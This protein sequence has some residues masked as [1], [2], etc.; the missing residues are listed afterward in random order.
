MDNNEYEG[1]NWLSVALHN[2]RLKACVCIREASK[3]AAVVKSIRVDV[4]GHRRKMTFLTFCHSLCAL[5]NLGF[6][7]ENGCLM[8]CKLGTWLALLTR[9]K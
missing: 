3:M 4:E 5:R 8:Q 6:G 1:A 2:L 9:T 7:V